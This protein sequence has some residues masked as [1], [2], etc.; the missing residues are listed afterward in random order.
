MPMQ[1]TQEMQVQSLCWEDPPE[2]E[3]GTCS[4]IVAQEIPWTGEPGG[5]LSMGS[6]TQLN[7]RATKLCI[8]DAF[9]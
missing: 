2:K 5:L 9:K 1:E 8:I 4:S 3:M 7:T 6:Q